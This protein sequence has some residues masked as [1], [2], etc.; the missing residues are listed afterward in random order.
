LQTLTDE[1]GCVKETVIQTHKDAVNRLRRLMR[2]LS[3]EAPGNSTSY[4]M[5]ISRREEFIICKEI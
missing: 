5:R 3:G 2:S 1:C 4:Q